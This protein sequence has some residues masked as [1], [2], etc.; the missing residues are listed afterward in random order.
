MPISDFTE[1]LKNSDEYQNLYNSINKTKSN[2]QI[3]TI[4]ESVA[5]LCSSIA[6]D[7]QRPTLII[8]PSAFHAINLQEN[9]SAWTSSNILRFPEVE[10]L[11]YERII[12]D[13][14]TSMSR[15]DT[16]TKITN[17]N[18]FPLVVSSVSAI[19]QQ[20]IESSTLILSS[21]ELMRNQKI[22]MEELTRFLQQTGYEFESTVTDQGTFSRRGGILDIFPV[23]SDNPYRIEFWGNEI[24]S[25]RRFDP[26]TQKSISEINEFQLFPANEILPSFLNISNLENQISHIDL[27]NCDPESSER[28]NN[29]L[30][31]L[32]NKESIDDIS[33]Y[34]GFFS[35]ESLIDYMPKDSLII[36]YRPADIFNHY[37]EIE[38]RIRQLK[39]NKEH[40]GQI[41]YNFPIS[42]QSWNEIEKQIATKNH[43]IEI[44]PW[45]SET[46]LNKDIHIMPFSSASAYNG[47]LNLLSLEIKNF[48]QDKN[49]TV[50]YTSHHTRLTET[51]DSIIP[52]QFIISSE[53]NQIGPGFVLNTKNSKLMILSDSEIFGITKQKRGIRKKSIK[54]QAFFNEISIGDYVV[55]VEHGIAKFLGTQKR[56]ENENEFLV[57]QYAQGDKLYVPMDHLDRVAPYFAPMEASPSLTRLGT[58]EWSRAKNR[59]EKSTKELAAELL[60]LYAQRE[61]VKG[62]SMQSDTKWQI[63]LEESFPYEETDDQLTTI[64]EVKEDM[65]SLRP[66]DRLICGDVG[67]GKTEIAIRAAFKA[68]MDNKQV[69][70]LVPTTVL[71]QQ[72]Y[73]TFSERLK[74]F[75]CTVTALS[76]FRTK[77][78][79][80]QILEKINN[81]KID[82]CVGTHRLVQKDVKFKDLGL[83]IIDEEQRFGV[84][85]KEKFKQLRKEVDILT[86]TATPIPRTL[87][88]SLAGVRDMSTI[89]TAPEE[90]LPIKT[91]VSEFSDD[92]IREAILRELDRQGQIYF[93]HNRVNNIEYIAEYLS[94][95]VPNAQIGI[96]HG[97]MTE[98]ELEKVMISFSEGLIDVLVCTTIIESGLDIPNANTLIIN[99]ADT[100]G[101]AQLY[102]LRGRIGRSSKR[103]YSYLLI[104]RR[105]SISET[106]EKR[107]KAMLSATELGSGFKIAMKDLEIR[108]AG[109]ILGSEQS[110]HIHTVG[111]DLYTRLLSAAVE[112]LRKEQSNDGNSQDISYKQSQQISV[113]LGIPASIPKEYIED[114]TI[115]LNFYQSL[116]N[117][118]NKEQINDFEKELKDRFGNFP[119]EVENLIFVLKLKIETGLTGAQSIT[120]NGK[121]IL[122]QF[123]YSL[124][125]MKSILNKTIG[126]SWQIGNQQIR[127]HIDDLGE[128]WETQLLESMTKL[129][130]LQQD[131]TSKMSLI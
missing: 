82:I 127:C 78:E 111:Y 66:M 35:N 108:G 18:H 122:I 90:R 24:D 52:K 129:V 30:N 71:A 20:T 87:H 34:Q 88:M 41:P 40:N 83:I 67:Y 86:L 58:Q 36:L 17:S 59:V 49:T 9:L 6:S 43:K 105:Q 3:Q 8:C 39:Q 25:I 61:L 46:L 72:H 55:H 10:N 75:P 114:I 121:Q 93:L 5:F 113:D 47:D 120:K 104:P 81:G 45:G 50:I 19:C 89:T 91:F 76:R 101:L 21:K 100:F 28:I 94:D 26:E 32:L 99:R 95:L 57:L 85:H 2:I 74:S 44:M 109:N 42:H 98:K 126:E 15:I 51:L 70:V 33:L 60:R 107:L 96:A 103:G 125:N 27:Q 128:N 69:A 80:K 4:D 97:Q 13:K 53:S 37:W 11:P 38:E 68:V 77:A 84:S 14:E 29:D 63:Q 115:R 106:A 54:R 22:T 1:F 79:Q 123:P 112:D 16:I 130:S 12:S 110:G 65:E 131:L 48:N 117:I 64:S 92:L 119:I 73:K 116:N 56:N 62:H 118:R 31:D 7:Y 124:S 23:G 102:Q